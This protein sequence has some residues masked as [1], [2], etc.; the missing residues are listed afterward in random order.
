MAKIDASVDILAAPLVTSQRSKN[1]S[2]CFFFFT[3]TLQLNVLHCI[4]H[5]KMVHSTDK[6]NAS[7]SFCLGSAGHANAV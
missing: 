3:H 4:A 7:S 5:R 6:P 2:A 1:W